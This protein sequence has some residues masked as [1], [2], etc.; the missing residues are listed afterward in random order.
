[1]AYNM[2]QKLADNIQAIE[3]A[4]RYDDNNPVMLFQ[5]ELLL[6]YSGFGGI[7]AILLPAGSKDLWVENGAI[8]TDLKLHAPIMELHKIL[9]HFFNEDQYKEVISSLRNSVL[10]SFYTPKFIPEILYQSLSESGF[11]PKNI[12]EPSAGTGV[13]INEAAD[14]FGKLEL[15]TAVEKDIL[16][17]KILAAINSTSSVPTS[18]NICGF[19]DTSRDEDEK[20]DLIAGNIP[21]GNFSVFDTNIRNRDVTGKIHNYFFAKGLDKLRDGGLLAF[22][23]T[24]AFLN[25]EGNK[26]AREYVFSRADFISLSVLP[27]NLMKETG[28]TEAPTHLLV[29][30]KN[31]IKSGYG[32][33]EL[34]LLETEKANNEFGEYN[35]NKY[36]QTHESKIILA[37]TISPGTNQYGKANQTVWQSGDLT[38]ISSRLAENLKDGLSRNFNKKAFELSAVQTVKRQEKGSRKLTFLPVPESVSEPVHL[39]LGIFDVAPVE[40]IN[41]SLAY[42]SAEDEKIIRKESVRLV[43]SVRTS[44]RP[45]HDSLV[46]L[47][48]RRIKPA[49]FVYKI[50][51]NVEEIKAS[52]KWVNAMEL[53]HELKDLSL[54]LPDFSY[55]FIYSGDPDLKDMFGLV[56]KENITLGQIKPFYKDGVLVHIN[57]KTGQLSSIDTETNSAVFKP[58]ANQNNNNFFA[59]YCNLRDLYFVL[60][61]TD[62]NLLQ[63]EKIR[64]ELNK[65]Y[66]AFTSSHG[67]LN[68]KKNIVLLSED[69]AFGFQMRVS[70]ERQVEDGFIK[71]DILL[72]ALKQEE[73]FSTSDP[74]EAL[75]RSL[76]EKGKVD[77][78]FIANAT[79]LPEYDVII[80][81]SKQIYLNPAL[82]E[83]ETSDNFLSGNVV[84]KLKKSEIHLKLNPENRFFQQSVDA[85]K[86]VQPERIP[87]ELLDFNLGERWIPIKYYERYASHLF[88]TRTS[89]SYFSSID[90]FKVNTGSLNAKITQEYA[91]SPRSGS[92][93]Y[94][95]T[96]LEHALENTSP[97]FSYE[98][99]IGDNKTKRI[100]DNEAIQIGHEKIEQIRNGFVSWLAALAQQDKNE[101]ENLYNDT[102]N[103]YVLR[104][105]DGSH[106]TFPGLDKNRLGIKDLYSSQKDAAWRIIQNRGAL[107]DHEVGLGK[108]LTMVVSAV[109]MKRL[110]IV[111]KPVIL[112]LKANVVQIAETF[113]QAYPNA[114]VLAPG[115]NDFVPSKRLQLFHEI[116][117][118]NWDC[119]I[120][121]HDQ[122]GKIPQ[123][124]DIQ[125]R[126]F[127]NELENV[128]LDLK[129]LKDL[130]GDI[131][132]SMLKGL[133]IRKTNLVTR[134][135]DVENSIEK[136]KDS[137][138]T[139]R[140]MGI[141][142]L[143]VDESHKFKNLTFT[144]RHTRVAGLGNM[145]GSQKALNM[146]FAVRELQDK[147]KSDLCVTFLSGTPISNSLTEMYL[148]F[149]YLRPRELERQAIE[150]F[151]GWAAVFAKK[152]TDF[153]FSVTNEIIAKERFRRFIKVP[154]LA[155]FYNDITDYK[156]AKHISLDKPAL[157]EV[158]VNIK[159]TPDQQDFIKNLMSFAKTGDATLLGRLPLSPSE[160]KAKMLIATNYAKKMAVDMRLI[161]PGFA[162]HPDNKINTCARN[163]LDIYKESTPHKGTQL[164][165][166]DIGTPGTLGFSVYHAL[167]EKL[168]ADFDIP[169]IEIAFIH[170]WQGKKKPELFKKMNR[171][172]IRIL[173]GSTEMAGTGTNVQ[174]R[175]VATH[176]LDIPWTPK[177]L[178]QRNG[179][180][181]RQGNI[182]AKKYYGNVVMNYIYAT[183]QSLDNYKF[184]L[185]KNK[186]TFISQ[187]KNSELNVRSIDE[188]SIDEKSGM[189]FSEYIAVLSGDTTLLEKS[190]L[191]KK[192]A[193]LESLKTAHSRELSRATYQ[194]KDMESEKSKA[195]SLVE[196]LTL[197]ENLY[198]GSLKF[199]KDGSKD[200]PI[201]ING[202]SSADAAVIGAQII[203]LAGNWKREEQVEASEVI[204]KLYGFNLF[205][206]RNSGRFEKDGAYEYGFYNTFYAENSGSDIKYT[207]NSG[208]V[209]VDN[210]KLAARY[211]L[212]AI[213][214]ID[215]LKEKYIQDLYHLNSNIPIVSQLISKPFERLNELQD[216]KTELSRLEREIILKIQAKTMTEGDKPSLANKDEDLK[217]EDRIKGIVIKMN[218]GHTENCVDG[219]QAPFRQR[220]SIRV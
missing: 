101:I 130:G 98:I 204:G 47:T 31:V 218:E 121:T 72:G 45:E 219:H 57:G 29:V 214:K 68:S 116:K 134:L 131:S 220:K 20:Y 106:L 89:V 24:D 36:I 202:V 206:K 112:A 79:G 32:A 155:L 39:Q 44:L 3:I 154:E 153:E 53:S 27:D 145:E 114:R 63:S 93:M 61:E 171:G 13:F 86:R 90:V 110:G 217:K 193:V 198:K 165:F 107:I 164:I 194:L 70:L 129:T 138:I 136:K 195:E 82:N 181:A 80:S 162:D 199:G 191:E 55:D 92:P 103:C 8:E 115:E 66:D 40:S 137:G 109:E 205:I 188:G 78:E 210:P 160:D 128:E 146:L 6:K 21:F 59:S 124:P 203:K 60:H 216:M 17:G 12:Y 30:Q 2:Q 141:D 168:T 163:V 34:L 14:I 54:V 113:K 158:L 149:K 190:K 156:T 122:F 64:I 173:L 11:V 174:A 97:F 183:E 77:L 91:V 167:K 197:D 22:I 1:M 151:D 9:K 95:Y 85:L 148:L 96:L 81:L 19:E 207:Y 147:F 69:L 35:I 16:T 200:N 49:N 185:L 111:C 192:V 182:V 56:K 23:T 88:D 100:P 42:L 123:A 211:F 161:S 43:S 67:L 201:K 26:G 184:N 133:E 87:F 189:N 143:F 38:A 74:A 52:A 209:N 105:F 84:S 159:P 170:D 83:W 10:S 196:K 176:D 46:V 186:Q 180:G 15:I 120:M 75:A 94:G 187:M 51:S 144:T 125:K 118:N 178:E 65:I 179:R 152:T 119:V 18:V 175:M 139:F 172:E 135:K 73:L 4:L 28:N 41:K 213:D 132:K 126:I 127:Q 108:T 140:D 48:A 102:Y 150:N 104:Q 5:R 215:S 25:T 37:D 7:K 169:A 71:S 142:H 50:F 76:N 177:D 208:F 58:I 157:K 33:D 62:H 99:S 117:N 212:N 166:C